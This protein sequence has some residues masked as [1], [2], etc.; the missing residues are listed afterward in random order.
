MKVGILGGTFDPPHLGHLMAAEIAL[1]EV[2]KVIWVPSFKHAFGKEPTSFKHRCKMVRE[3]IKDR[4]DM[5]FNRIE[6]D[7]K[8]PQ[9]TETV[10][11]ELIK[12]EEWKKDTYRFILGESEK[13]YIHKWH[14]FKEV[15]RLAPPLWITMTYPHKETRSTTIREKLIRGIEPEGML[16]DNVLKYIKEHKLYV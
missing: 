13:A 16:H 1:Q 9:W 10:I 11:K 6:R 8:T 3:M 15:A 5:W 12:Q 14:D 2:K 4:K 7:L